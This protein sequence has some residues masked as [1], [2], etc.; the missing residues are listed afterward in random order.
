MP[1][2]RLRSSRD[3]AAVL[4]SGRCRRG[5][6]AVVQALDVDDVTAAQVTVVAS[7]KVGTAVARNRAK[8]LLREASRRIAWQPGV[9]VV[10]IARPG[11]AASGLAD[12]HADVAAGAVTLGAAAADGGAT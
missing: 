5:R 2:Q 12:V 11:C 3:I 8:R 6:L 7:R 4:R 9:H 10:L 1:S